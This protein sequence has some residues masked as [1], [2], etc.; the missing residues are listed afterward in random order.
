MGWDREAKIAKGSNRVW[1][2]IGLEMIGRQRRAKDRLGV[3]VQWLGKRHKRCHVTAMIWIDQN[4]QKLR[5]QRPVNPAGV[6]IA[7]E[8]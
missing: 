1:R 2:S 3:A 6:V 7:G 8:R 4:F 5:T